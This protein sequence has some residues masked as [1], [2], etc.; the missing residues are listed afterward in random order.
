MRIVMHYNAE[1]LFKTYNKN[2]QTPCKNKAQEPQKHWIL[3]TRPEKSEP[4]KLYRRQKGII[5]HCTHCIG[6][7]GNIGNIYN[8]EKI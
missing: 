3:E 8:A 6:N 7:I 1:L 5:M 4:T 2:Q